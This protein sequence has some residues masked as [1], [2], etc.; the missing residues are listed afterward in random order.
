MV[1]SVA[2][3]LLCC[4]PP[5]HYPLCGVHTPDFDSY[6]NKQM[7]T[8]VFISISQRLSLHFDSAST[9]RRPKPLRA[10]FRTLV[11][12]PER[13]EDTDLSYEHVSRA[14]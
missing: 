3:R 5:F 10:C 13:R 12:D 4:F 14:E 9:W 6:G 8:V 2:C 1:G 11:P 7:L